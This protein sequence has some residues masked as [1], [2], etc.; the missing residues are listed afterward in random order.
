MKSRV[1]EMD[2]SKDKN[3]NLKIAVWEDDH[4]VYKPEKEQRK[5]KDGKLLDMVILHQCLAKMA[6]LKKWKDKLDCAGL[7]VFTADNAGDYKDI[8]QC[9]RKTW[10]QVSMCLLREGAMSVYGNQQPFPRAPVSRC[11]VGIE[12]YKLPEA[13]A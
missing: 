10:Q 6:T 2:D 11:W 5:G 12:E 13:A 4:W 8:A 7:V 1:D 9:W 3:P